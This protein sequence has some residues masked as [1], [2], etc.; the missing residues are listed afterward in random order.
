MNAQSEAPSSSILRRATMAAALALALTGAARAGDWV[1][2]PKSEA[3][4][5]DGGVY[6]GA[7]YAVAQ[8][9]L[10]GAAVT[11]WR[12]PGEAGAPPTFDFAG[13]DNLDGAAVLYPQP[14]R[15]DEDGSL[16]IGYQHQVAFP[17]R[18]TPA[19]PQKPVTLD[20]RLDYA[21][22]DKIC[23]PVHAQLSEVLAPQPQAP[24]SALLESAMKDVPKPLDGETAASQA[25]VEPAPPAGGKPQWRVA[26]LGGE[27]RDL[28]VEPP[29]GFYFDVKPAKAKNAFLLTLVQHP[30]KRMR[31]EA[32]LRVTIA[33]PA[34]VEFNL[35]LPARN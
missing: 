6:N 7:R 5:V 19:D 8:I 13:S 15:I 28:F 33:G 27:A 14:A 9:R 31:P 21:V 3:R 26:I 25:S 24:D 35:S 34:P 20:L 18:V 16:A 30:A 32:P 11:Y 1:A 23:I 22:C 2:G 10:A 4:L 17:I 12:D 29:D